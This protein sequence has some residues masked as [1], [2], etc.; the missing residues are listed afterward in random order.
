MNNF[1]K[2][3][4]DDEKVAEVAIA[5]E[6]PEDIPDVWPKRIFK[7]Y[8]YGNQSKIFPRK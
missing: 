5:L 2:I 8:G 4:L 1:H 6:H 3:N 7:I